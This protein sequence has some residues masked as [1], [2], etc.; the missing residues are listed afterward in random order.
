MISTMDRELAA[1]RTGQKVVEP[2]GSSGKESTSVKH[3][4]ATIEK[5]VKS[6][7]S[8]PPSSPSIMSQ[9]GSSRR[10][11]TESMISVGSVLSE[12]SPSIGLDRRTST[13]ADSPFKSVLRRTPESRLSE[14]RSPLSH[15]HT[16]TNIMLDK[17]EKKALSPSTASKTV[18]EVDG[19]GKKLT[20]ILSNKSS[21][22]KSSIR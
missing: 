2:R 22:R 7:F 3:L 10:N 1:L 8:T 14:S 21:V 17:E 19:G 12:T 13:P 15:R 9:E 16:I 6:D 20:G 18:A 11:S 5:Q 4:I